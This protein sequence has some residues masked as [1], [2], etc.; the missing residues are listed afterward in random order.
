MSSNTDYGFMK[1][2][3]GTSASALP[4][5]EEEI[6]QLLS[7]FISNALI[8]STKYASF[9]KRNGVTKQDINLGLKYEVREFFERNTLSDDLKE[10][11]E[12]YNKLEEEEPIKFKVEYIDTR[13]GSI[14]ESELFETEEEAE[15]FICELEQDENFTEFT[16]I[17]L[18]ESDL[19][20][21]DVVTEDENVDEFKK[22][23]VEQIRD[24]NME[25]R[26]LVSKIHNYDT[27]WN[28]WEPE[29]PLHI[30]LKNGIESMIQ[31]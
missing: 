10:M 11:Q 13:V 14:E 26:Q 20:M 21:D 19:L 16:I 1:S 23:T 29:T 28:S 9:C 25:D 17:E 6:K 7:L 18:T 31:R 8:T 4:F 22:I 15:D 3:S 2:G 12:E 5:S 30:I 24:L 27:T